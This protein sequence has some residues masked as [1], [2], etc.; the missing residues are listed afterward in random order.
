[1]AIF[2][3]FLT[4]FDLSETFEIVFLGLAEGKKS[5]SPN[6]TAYNPLNIPDKLYL[7]FRFPYYPSNNNLLISP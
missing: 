6:Q 2:T 5:L 3:L 7:P 4:F 1:M